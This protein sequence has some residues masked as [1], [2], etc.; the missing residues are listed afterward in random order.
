MNSLRLFLSTLVLLTIT[1]FAQAD[2]V[3]DY[4]QKTMR[5]QHIPGLSL[6]VLRNGKIIKEKGYGYAS[7][8]QQG[9]AQP[10]TV[11]ALAST[12]K[13]FVATAILLL[14]QEKQLLLADKISKYVANLP[15]S[16]QE[17]TLRHLL[18]HTAGIKN[19]PELGLSFSHE[20]PPEKVIAALAKEPLEFVPGTRWAYSN[21]GFV[22]LAMV[23]QKV[24]GK[25]YDV[26]LQERVFKPLGM[27]STQRD[28]PDGIIPQ[29][30]TGYLWQ[31]GALH[32]ATYLKYQMPHHGD[33]GI[34][35]TVRDL[36]KWE[37][38]LTTDRV[39]FAA[40]R[41]AMWTPT[42][43]NDGSPAGYGLGWFIEKRNG[44]RSFSHA[45]GA[46][47]T[48]AMFAHYPDDKL[49]V[50]LLANQFGAVFVQAIEKGVAQCYLPALKP[51]KTLS[52]APKLLDSY[53]GYYNLFGSQVVELHREKAE[54]VFNNGGYLNNALLPLSETVFVAEDSDQ[55]VVFTRNAQQLPTRL[56]LRLGKD[57]HA[58]AFLGPLVTAGSAPSDPNLARTQRIE[59]VL[60][61][62][63]RGVKT[64]EP[65]ARELAPHTL[66]DFSQ[67]PAPELIGI[68]KLSFIYERSLLS[69]TIERH[70]EKVSHVL[71]F[72]ATTEKGIR[73][74]LV[75][76]TAD[77]H[78]ADEDVVGV[79]G[80]MPS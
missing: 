60:K 35:S 54:L 59:A 44:H 11:Y 12:T 32:N 46:P 29:R 58:G 13:P 38:A 39:L 47:G 56:V 62:L 68:Q 78:V 45:G 53:T 52:L 9:R 51:Q 63:A 74:V 57:E 37:T 20:T 61:A 80:T 30:A 1:R 8:E 31:G 40:S 79:R 2:A 24:T 10:E 77:G 67:G 76:L 34:L 55:G 50:I 71:A 49:T 42:K 14:E 66:E 15:E 43:L 6:L 65:I 4:I 7:L 3:D 26:F 48:A 41:D 27:N 16:W 69:S 22:L 75:Y 23:V 25:S 64:D 19:Y 21:T 73:G 36:A 72:L 18:S 33:E 5:R 28:S 70:R 17:I